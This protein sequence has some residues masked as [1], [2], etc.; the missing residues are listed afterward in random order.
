MTDTKPPSAEAIEAAKDWLAD[1]YQLVA[2][3]GYTKFVDELAKFADAFAER[4]AA[5]TP[6]GSSIGDTIRSICPNRIE[7][8]IN[9]ATAECEYPDCRDSMCG[10]WRAE[11]ALTAAE[12]G[13]Q[14]AAIEECADTC[15][16]LGH[17][18]GSNV[19]PAIEQIADA[20]RALADKPATG[21]DEP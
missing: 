5:E 6:P 18:S 20:I 17:Y 2:A 19:Q 3:D 21:K 14:R 9:G 1:R 4:R 10:F 12:D 16:A 7:T 15:R 13:A 8:G 11:K